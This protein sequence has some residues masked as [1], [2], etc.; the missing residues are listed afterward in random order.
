MAVS[1]R[2]EA[3]GFA[4][5]RNSTHAVCALPIFAAFPPV[6]I[7]K[8]LGVTS[9]E[10]IP[11][12]FVLIEEGVAYQ[13]L[14]V[15]VRGLLQVHTHFDSKDRTLAVLTSPAILNADAIF[16]DAV[17]LGSARTLQAS[18]V[19]RIAIHQAR[20]LF[21]EERAFA[22]AINRELVS[23]YRN[24]LREFKNIRT[25]TGIQRLA[26]WILTMFD[27][28]GTPCEIRI[29]YDKATLAARLGVAAAGLSRDLA[30]LAPLGVTVR[31]RTLEIG[32]V[33]R[34]RELAK[35]DGLNVPPVP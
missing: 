35:L 4:A 27:S 18:C 24:L 14:L 9:I 16:S 29:P 25:R 30:R 34:L 23:N 21:W 3:K 20:R 15:L 6:I 2:S 31:G 32:N 11:A 5:N 17:S 13:S 7:D 12:G 22:D 1:Q 28:A 33:E 19:A 26:A 8:L 10:Q